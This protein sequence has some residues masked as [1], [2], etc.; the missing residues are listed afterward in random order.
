[1]RSLKR[2][3]FSAM[4]LALCMVLPIITGG[5]PQIGNALSPMHLPVLLCGFICGWPY[6]AVVGLIA[7][8]MRSMIFN[9]PV[10]YP[11]AVAMS[12]ELATYGF[13]SGFLYKTFPKNNKYIYLSLIISIIIGRIVWGI[14]RYI[15]AGLSGS[16][17][18]LSM[19]LAGAFT[20]A[21]PGIIC[22]IILVPLI[23]ILFKKVK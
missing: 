9:A 16:V 18:N 7:P 12:F 10:M 2:I 19:F 1:M 15:M 6:G 14:S 8:V 20:Q 21:I 23:V 22:N 13:I 4:F 17:F 5:I 3:T 11:T